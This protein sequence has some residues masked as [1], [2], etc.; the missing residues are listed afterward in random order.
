MKNL[1]LL[2]FGIISLV[3]LSD[4]YFGLDANERRCYSVR[5]FFRYRKFVDGCKT[6][7]SLLC[8]VYQD[9][10]YVSLKPV[11]GPNNSYG[12]PIFVNSYNYYLKDSN[13][14][15]KPSQKIFI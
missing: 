13:I 15:H 2:V 9:S 3:G 4:H 10:N 14:F 11:E 5:Y 1:N 12:N 8:A 6:D 7:T